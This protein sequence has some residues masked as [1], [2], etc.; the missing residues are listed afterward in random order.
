[1]TKDET[2]SQYPG[3]TQ[4]AN[5]RGYI[6][7]TQRLRLAIAVLDTI[8]QTVQDGDGLDYIDNAIDAVAER[9]A[10]RDIIPLTLSIAD[11]DSIYRDAG[12][13]YGVGEATETQLEDGFLAARLTLEEVLWEV[14]PES[15]KISNRPQP[16][17]RVHKPRLV[18]TE[19]Y[20]VGTVRKVDGDRA[21]IAWDAGGTIWCPLD[22][23]DEVAEEES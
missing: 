22:T 2:D 12:R 16:G 20:D 7:D 14:L 18:N 8:A 9:L 1:M 3:E 23:L 19:H 4:K 6:D 15:R 21:L 10:C 13:W 17:D 5:L 11:S